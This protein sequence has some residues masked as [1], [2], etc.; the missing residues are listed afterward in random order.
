MHWS[1]PN[2]GATNETGFTALPGG[3]RNANGTFYVIGNKGSWW[4]AT[5]YEAYGALYVD[6]DWISSYVGGGGNFKEFDFV[7]V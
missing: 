5:E 3:H 1:S 6:M 2:T 7:V 4:S